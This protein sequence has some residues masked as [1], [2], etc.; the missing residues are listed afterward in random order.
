M[1]FTMAC[2]PASKDVV[3]LVVAA[4]SKVK[5]QTST[6]VVLCETD[7]RPFYSES[8]GYGSISGT[9]V[10]QSDGQ[11]NS[12]IVESTEGTPELVVLLD[13][14]VDVRAGDTLSASIVLRWG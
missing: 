12:I 7:P 13:S 1:A 2:P 5:F 11:L 10:A 4:A 8:D 6:L 9:C 3:K 14:T